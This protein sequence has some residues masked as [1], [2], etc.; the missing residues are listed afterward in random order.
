MVTDHQI[1]RLGGCDGR[2]DPEPGV[3]SLH[4]EGGQGQPGQHQSKVQ[5]HVE[6]DQLKSQVA[7]AV[8]YQ[9]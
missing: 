5:G 6:H 9:G 1:V 8:Y 2:G 3:P 7:V 4:P